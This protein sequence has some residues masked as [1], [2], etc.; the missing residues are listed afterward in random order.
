MHQISFD[1][2]AKGPVVPTNTFRRLFE[3]VFPTT[4]FA[5][6]TRFSVATANFSS[7]CRIGFSSTKNRYS[8][9]ETSNLYTYVY[10]YLSEHVKNNIKYKNFPYTK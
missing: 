4:R 5:K 1:A 3:A 6:V 10:I 9:Y 2:T 7:L 8:F